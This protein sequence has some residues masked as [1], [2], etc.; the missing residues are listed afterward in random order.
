VPRLRLEGYSSHISVSF[1]ARDDRR[2]SRRYAETF[3]P[4]LM[5]LMDRATSPGLLVRPR[6][7]R[8]ELCGEHVSD[9]AARAAVAFAVGSVRALT[10]ASRGALAAL[11]VR[12]DLVPAV[13][14]YGI[15][16]D[17]RAFGPDLYDQ[18]RGA[19]LET[20]AGIPRLAQQ[21]LELAWA[22]ARESLASDV[23]AC[24]LEMADRMVHGELALPSEAPR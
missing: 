18:G 24:D 23:G 15:Y 4:A 22:L 6:P 9:S 1:A 8:L 11:R 13:E 12:A 2:A 3:A 7:G 5:L 20:H 10:R 19:R 21:Q 17:R 14:R 16:V